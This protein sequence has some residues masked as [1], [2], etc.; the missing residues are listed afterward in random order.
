MKI[1]LRRPRYADLMSTF[2]VFVTMT[3][4]AYGVATVSTSDIQNRA[5]TTPKLADEAVS[6][7]K[8]EP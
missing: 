4:V 7:A 8:I 1:R 3:G 2:A 6:S 5:V